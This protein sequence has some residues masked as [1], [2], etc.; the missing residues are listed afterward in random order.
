MSS[1]IPVTAEQPCPHCGKTDWC[2][3]IG[4]LSVCKRK[5]PPA[6]GWKRTSKTDREGTPFYAPVTQERLAKGTYRDERKTWVYT[7]RAG[8]LLVRLVREKY[9][10]PR[11]ING[12]LKKSRSWQEHMTNND[13]WQPGRNGIPLTEIPLYNYQ[14]VQEAIYERPQ[15]IFITEGENC[16]DAL[17]SL[18]FVSTTNFGGSGQ[19]KDSCTADLK[20]ALHLILCCDRD[21]PG[22]KHFDEVHESVKKLDG[23]KVEW[24][25]AYPDSP[26]WSA[27]K[28][29]KSGGVDVADW[30]KD[31]QLTADEIIEAVEPH[32]LPALTPL[33]TENFPPPAPVLPKSKLQ[34][35]LQTIKLCWGEQ[36]AYNELTNKVEFDGLPLNL[37]TLRVE[38]VEDLEMD[39]GRDVAVEF[40]TA[41]ALK[42]SYHPVQKYLELVEMDHPHPGIDLDN[43][44]SRYL[45]T[46]EPLHQILL[47]KHLIASVA[48]IF[49]PG[50]KHDSALIL[51]GDQGRR[52]STFLK[53]LY[54]ARF[55]IDTMAKCSDRDELMR[56][57]SCWCLEW[58]ELETVF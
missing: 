57:H 40:C 15:P 39:I 20:G 46:D 23:V 52:K 32:R 50:C 21:Q 51:Q 19:W 14:R 45:G 48:R 22:V 1:I 24:L 27:D 41:I 18:G 44:A 37:D 56:L 33:P 34:A 16:A 26:F 31:F 35:Q 6:D 25:Y 58:A 38:M 2:Y 29:P 4:E 53:L 55:F 3:S 42:K 30:I 43:L 7:D 5:A 54:G 11:L 12:K 9:S 17:S 13:G 10:Q 28:L 36:L 49:Q 8:K 47:K